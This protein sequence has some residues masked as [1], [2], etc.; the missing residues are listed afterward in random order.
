MRKLREN[1]SLY[2]CWVWENYD[3]LCL[4]GDAMCL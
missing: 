1:A 4:L 2:K 3:L